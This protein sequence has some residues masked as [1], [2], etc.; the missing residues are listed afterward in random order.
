MTPLFW[1]SIR[2]LFLTLLN[3]VFQSCGWAFWIACSAL[4]CGSFVRQPY[5]HLSIM[6]RSI[7]TSWWLRKKSG[8]VMAEEFVTLLDLLLA[9][10]KA[11]CSP[12]CILAAPS[13]PATV[14]TEALNSLGG[15]LVIIK[16]PS[17]L[18]PRG[19]QQQR[20]ATAMLRVTF[21]HHQEGDLKGSFVFCL[22]SGLKAKNIRQ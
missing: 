19:N 7:F 16:L 22:R 14:T 6:H 8:N 12:S 1:W 11:N 15:L 2:G 21:S 10:E 4:I 5:T 9:S 20:V 18:S 3:L 13:L 17:S